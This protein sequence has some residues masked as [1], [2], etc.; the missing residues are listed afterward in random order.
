M[1]HLLIA[2]TTVESAAQAEALAQALVRK[3]IIACAQVDGPIQSHYHWQDK[4]ECAEE[5]RLTLKF[6]SS[7]LSEVE[8]ALHEEHPYDVPQWVVWQAD[9]VSPEYL[10]WVQDSCKRTV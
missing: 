1:D 2:T 4:L 7:L 9:A 5:Y 6:P 10:R 3:R 8:S